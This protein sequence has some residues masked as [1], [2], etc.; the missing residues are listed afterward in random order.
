MQ[1]LSIFGRIVK[2]V[3][4]FLAKKIRSIW[5]PMTIDEDVLMVETSLTTVKS[6]DFTFLFWLLMLEGKINFTPQ[7]FK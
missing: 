2:Q 3:S 7:V 1:I 5:P 4:K 6:F